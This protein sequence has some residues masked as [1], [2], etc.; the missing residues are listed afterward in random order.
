MNQ[1]QIRDSTA[2]VPET[3]MTPVGPASSDEDVG[4]VRIVHGCRRNATHLAVGSGVRELQPSLRT[5]TIRRKAMTRT[6]RRVA[7]ATV[8]LMGLT[9]LAGAQP[10]PDAELARA[11]EQV[12]SGYLDDAVVALNALVR[13]LSPLVDRKDDLAQAYL[14]LG[15]AYAQQD[16]EKSAR[17][18]FREAL[19]LEPRV[20]LAEGWPPKVTRLFAAE[21]AVAAT[22]VAPSRASESRAPAAQ[23]D[24]EAFREFAQQVEAA[25]QRGDEPFFDQMFDRDA[26][27]ALAM[28]GLDAPPALAE[29]FRSI[30]KAAWRFART[31]LEQIRQGAATY[32]FLRLR[33]GLG[34]RPQ[35]LFRL[36][37]K[38]GGTNFHEYALRRDAS[39]V[40][41]V[42]FYLYSTGE[43][44]S[45]ILRRNWLS[46]MSA[47]GLPGLSSRLAGVDSERVKHI[48]DIQRIDT[49]HE[50]GQSAEALGLLLKL[51]ASVQSDR[52]LLRIRV[53]VA[54]RV[55]EREH[56]EAVEAFARRFPNDPALDLRLIDILAARKQYDQALAAIERLQQATGGDAYFDGLSGTVSYLKGDRAA[57]RAAAQKAVASEPSFATGHLILLRLAVEAKDHAETARLLRAY[58]PYAPAG[59]IASLLSDPEFADF[60][61][62]EEHR[63]WAAER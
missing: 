43:W 1:S 7:A 36:L 13:R 24:A 21:R 56:T 59:S 12:Q 28:N 16:V 30:E 49:L 53:G 10:R 19:R 17:A 44:K 25:A 6:S 46:G 42:D 45:D 60:V 20:S 63:R 34:G 4:A 58:E 27:L 55:G 22:A 61:R 2:T 50:A 48:A 37:G 54:Q 47:A 41:A 32:R 38:D 40:K 31:F 14:W 26:T 9:A 35:A 62:S 33:V 57:A 8:V 29:Q 18:S 39:G 3:A 23:S 52:N 5:D 51:P 11:I 15:I